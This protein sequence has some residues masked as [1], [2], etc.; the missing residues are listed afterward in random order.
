[1]L[2]E[3]VGK[4]FTKPIEP[5]DDTVIAVDV[6]SEGGH[7]F[8]TVHWTTADN[9]VFEDA[10]ASASF[11]TEHDDFVNGAAQVVGDSITVTDDGLVDTDSDSTLLQNDPTN[12]QQ[13]HV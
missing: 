11:S 8:D 12:N 5:S 6:E 2:P 9:E 10:S 4:W 13:V 7:S 3:L 1:M